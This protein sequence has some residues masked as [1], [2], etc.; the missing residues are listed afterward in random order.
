MK[1]LNESSES[2][3]NRGMIARMNTASRKTKI[4][5]SIVKT[6]SVKMM[7]EFIRFKIPAEILLHYKAMFKDVSVGVPEGM[8]KALYR[9]ISVAKH[10][11]AFPT[12]IVSPGVF[13]IKTFSGTNRDKRSLIKAF[14]LLKDFFT[15]RA[16][17]FYYGNHMDTINITY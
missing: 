11:S 5:A 2:I 14:W 17:I 7:D 3:S 10:A 15:D 4:F 1:R 13:N 16:F 8:I 6:I 12:M 9:H